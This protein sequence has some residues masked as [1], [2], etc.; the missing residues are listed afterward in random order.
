MKHSVPG[1]PHIRLLLWIPIVERKKHFPFS[2][3][4]T[5][6]KSLEYIGAF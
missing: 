4:N 2:F 1:E 6:K 5:I 3:S